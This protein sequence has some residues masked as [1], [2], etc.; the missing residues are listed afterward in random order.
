M[1]YLVPESGTRKKLVPDCMTHASDF[2]TSFLVPES[3]TGSGTYVMGITEVDRY[4]D[5]CSKY[6]EHRPESCSTRDHCRH[7]VATRWRRWWTLRPSEF[8]LLDWFGIGRCSRSVAARTPDLTPVTWHT[9]SSSQL[10]LTS[11]RGISHFH[12]KLLPF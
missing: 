4:N 7:Q 6:G 10:Q 8:R 5:C 12:S 2:G 11:H 3:G 9:I 1:F